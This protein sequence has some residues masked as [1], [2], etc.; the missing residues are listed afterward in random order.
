MPRVSI[1]L[2]RCHDSEKW[3]VT[4][5]VSTTS[6][7]MMPTQMPHVSIYATST[8]FVIKWMEI[9]QK[10]LIVTWWKDKKPN[11]HNEKKGNSNR[12]LAIHERL[13][14][15]LGQHYNMTNVTK[16]NS[17]EDQTNYP[18]LRPIKVIFIWKLYIN[19]SF[20]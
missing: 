4:C 16:T 8:F 15:Q 1:S 12:T 20:E 11:L 2:P 18:E 19:I 9:R 17:E 10:G 13:K 7:T 14:Q 6:A 3:H 5:H